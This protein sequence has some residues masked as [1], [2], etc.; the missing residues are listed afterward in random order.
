MGAMEWCLEISQTNHGLCENQK[1]EALGLLH[2]IGREES[3][4]QKAYFRRV[5]DTGIAGVKVDFA[6]ALW[7]LVVDTAG[8]PA[9][10]NLILDIHGAVKSTGTE[11]TWPNVLTLEGVGRHEYHVTRYNAG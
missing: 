7:L 1:R 3:A 9:E 2:G 8:D 6:P 5:A 10:F 11:R 4:A